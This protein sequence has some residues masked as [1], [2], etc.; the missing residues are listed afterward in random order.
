MIRRREKSPPVPFIV[1]SVASDYSKHSK[2]A[3]N[4]GHIK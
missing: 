3:S 4:I 2:T 1:R